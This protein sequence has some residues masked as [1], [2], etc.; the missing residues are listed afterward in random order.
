MSTVECQF[1][2]AR[3]ILPEG[4]LPPEVRCKR[5]GRRVNISQRP[6]TARSRTSRDQRSDQVRPERLGNVPPPPFASLPKEAPKVAAYPTQKPPPVPFRNSP[7]PSSWKLPGLA[8]AAVIGLVITIIA[9]QQFMSGKGSSS[10]A[11]TITP[12]AAKTTQR[13]GDAVVDAGVS[14]SPKTSEPATTKPPAMT[15]TSPSKNSA[16]PMN[17]ATG[18][19]KTIE[20]SEKFNKTVYAN[21]ELALSQL[22]ETRLKLKEEDQE[23]WFLQEFQSAEAFNTMTQASFRAAGPWLFNNRPVFSIKL[24]NVPE[25]TSVRVQFLRLNETGK[26]LLAGSQATKQEVVVLD[27]AKP[28]EMVWFH[29]KDEEHPVDWWEIG[30]HPM[31]EV[32]QLSSISSPE[33]I[34]FEI[35]ITY[36]DG[37]ED[38]HLLANVKIMPP[39]IVETAYPLALGIVGMVNGQHPWI[40]R[41]LNDVNQSSLAKKLEIG[42]SGGQD[43]AEVLFAT[44]MIWRELH[45]RGL[46]YSSLPGSTDPH[47]QSMRCIHDTLTNKNANCVD[48]T[49][50]ICSFLERMGIETMVVLPKGH[51][52]LI[53]KLANKSWWGLE[54]TYLELD[55]PCTAKYRDEFLAEPSAKVKMHLLYSRLPTPEQHN[56]DCFLRAIQAGE[57]NLEEELELINN[58]SK[59][60]DL[61]LPSVKQLI[62]LFASEQDEKKQAD[63]INVLDRCFAHITPVI[64]A[65]RA[66]V[67]A[68]PVPKDLDQRFKLPPKPISTR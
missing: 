45:S 12:P 40:E 57:A 21:S 22:E 52:F 32:D 58:G 20:A 11:A 18:L 30:L 17:G 38:L 66:G 47:G 14:S 29:E 15:A 16:A 19:A 60:P 68:I 6:N 36:G 5:C 7:R 43:P 44:F 62:D 37:S 59:T 34:N 41:I 2:G 10:P 1:C 50:L 49:I 3:L 64:A 65:R 33:F 24:T 61:E 39:N 13:T 55:E 35:G 8:S 27:R 53:F 23:D 56:F 9:A 42:V 26:R 67:Q 28:Q 46:R 54:T 31:W 51:A 48:G 63:I 25:G 4:D